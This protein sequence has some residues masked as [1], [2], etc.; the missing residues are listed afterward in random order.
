MQNKVI[1]HFHFKIPNAGV[2]LTKHLRLPSTCG[3]GGRHGDQVQIS[4]PFCED[5]ENIHHCLLKEEEK[6]VKAQWALILGQYHIY[7]AAHFLLLPH[8]LGKWCLDPRSGSDS[9]SNHNSNNRTYSITATSYWLFAM[10]AVNCEP[11]A[12][13]SVH[14]KRYPAKLVLLVLSDTWL[15]LRAIEWFSQY[16]TAS[17]VA[18]SRFKPSCVWL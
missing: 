17:Q 3:L 15:R 12:T 8:C 14:L 10:C 11:N 2:R 5:H 7:R 18:E 1:H 9:S 6:V 4:C 16:H 13:M